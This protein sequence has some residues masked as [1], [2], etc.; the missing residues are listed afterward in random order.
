MTPH[1]KAVHALNTR[2]ERLQANL[3]T[4]GVESARRFLLQSIVITLG[5]GEALNAYIQA[6]GAHAER[7]H[8]AL[9][10]ENDALA[11]QHAAQLKSGQE[12]L[13]QF[14]AN[15]ADRVIRR[16]IE[17]T[18]QAM[19][20]IQKKLRRAANTLQ[21][22]LAPG[23]GLIDE[24]AGSVRRFAEAEGNDALKRGLMLIIGQAA[25]FYSAQP[26]LP[27]ETRIDAA[28]WEQAAIAE[29]AQAAD[30]YDAYARTGYQVLLALEG[31][32]MAVSA[33]PPR[34]AAE[35]MRRADDSAAARV[36]EITARFAAQ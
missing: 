1:E 15:P 11:A 10:Q 29:L 27:V 7:R 33:E 18:Q 30:F 12:L 32:T 34:T 19:A 25:G 22:E 16:E 31:V 28:A 3:R 14:K 17:R 6:V 35:A 20:A 5:V 21:R 2:L 8:G 26:E 24:L 4:A 13:A 36:K 23:L 9:R